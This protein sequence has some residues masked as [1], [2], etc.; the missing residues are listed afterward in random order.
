MRSST[1]CPTTSAISGQIVARTWSRMAAAIATH[2]R[3]HVNADILGLMITDP[4]WRWRRAV[5]VE[6]LELAILCVLLIPAAYLL[7]IVLLGIP[8]PAFA[9]NF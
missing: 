1:S 3:A 6:A 9:W 4:V 2:D 8:A 7:F 5:L